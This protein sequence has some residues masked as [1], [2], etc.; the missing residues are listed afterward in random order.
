MKKNFVKLIELKTSWKSQLDG[1][2]PVGYLQDLLLNIQLLKGKA[3]VNKNFCRQSKSGTPPFMENWINLFP[4]NL[5]WFLVLKYTCCLITLQWN[6]NKIISNLVQVRK[7]Q[8]YRRGL[9]VYWSDIN[10]PSIVYCNKGT[11][12]SPRKLLNTTNVLHVNK[13][14][15]HFTKTK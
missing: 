15:G 9:L 13:K 6:E 3:V 12:S 7:H 8:L 14:Q 10:S 4:G 11:L 5:R 2:W 1:G